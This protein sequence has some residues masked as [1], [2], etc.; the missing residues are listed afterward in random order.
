MSGH[1]KWATT[2]RAKASVDA[3]RSG[4]FTKLSKTIA[5]AAREGADPA[6]NFKLRM[7]ID[8]AKAMSMPKDNI[9]RA[10]ARGSGT[11]TGIALETL[12][13]EGFGPDG[14]ALMI[15]VVTDNKNRSSSEI[16]H[17]LADH[18]G[19]LGGSGSV[20]WM[21]D[22]RGIIRVRETTV[23]EP[24]ELTLIDAGLLDSRKDDEGTTLIVSLEQ[25]QKASEE[26]IRAGLTV[27]EAST[28]YIPKE[29]LHLDNDEKIIA[30]LEAIDD[31]DDV[32]N[33]YTNADI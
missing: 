20:A 11:D 5:V 12:L 18:G 27:E 14:V 1:S 13:Y 22:L 25:L 21:F 17:V 2:K 8:K 19:N 31:L 16:K 9:E 32:E 33:V 4:L 30:L 6:M 10:V 28:G 24:Q 26:A 29:H 23:S 7:A 3:K 15:Q